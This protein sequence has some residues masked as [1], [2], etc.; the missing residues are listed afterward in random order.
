MINNLSGST[1]T[2]I[3]NLKNKTKNELNQS[4]NFSEFTETS[5]EKDTPLPKYTSS[6]Q[7]LINEIKNDKAQPTVMLTNNHGLTMTDKY[8]DLLNSTRKLVMPA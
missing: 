3:K 8:K 5:S 1:M 6:T 2:L 7:A 4:V